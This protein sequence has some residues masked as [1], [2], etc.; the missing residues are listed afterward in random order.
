VTDP[1]I[2]CASQSHHAL[3]MPMG[4]RNRVTRPDLRFRSYR[5]LSSGRMR[6]VVVRLL[7]LI[8]LR[9]LGWIILL[10]CG[11]PGDGSR[12]VP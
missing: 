3:V 12:T 1:R 2:Q 10:A 5:S 9:V 6:A 8:L 11:D 7:Y 4:A